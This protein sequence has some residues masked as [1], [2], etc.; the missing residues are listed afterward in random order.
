MDYK[1]V[2]PSHKRL[3]LLKKKTLATL[4]LY[5]IPHDKIYI[6][7]AEDEYEE[8]KS[9]LLSYHVEKGAIGLAAQRNCITA[10]F[11]EGEKLFCMDDDIRRFLEYSENNNRHEQQLEDLDSF[12]KKGFEEATRLNV[13]LWG[14]YPVAN[15]RWMKKSVSK[16]LFFCYGCCYGLINRKDIQI[17]LALKEDYERSLRFYLRDKGVVRCHWVAPVQSYT[18]QKGGLH[19]VRTQE[20]EKE[21]CEQIKAW[22]PDLCSYKL[23]RGKWTLRLKRC[24]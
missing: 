3:A 7:V 15:G 14:L 13:S 11:P 24:V 20:K 9:S 5:G 23:V 18:K 19:D 2:I 4:D 8:Y 16:G 22:F 6:F 1:I 12:I 10:F 17:S 21:E